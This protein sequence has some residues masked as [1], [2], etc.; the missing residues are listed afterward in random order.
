[1]SVS[2]SHVHYELVLSQICISISYIHFKLTLRSSVTRPICCVAW[3][4]SSEC[5]QKKEKCVKDTM[6]VTIRG[7]G[8]VVWSLCT[9]QQTETT[10]YAL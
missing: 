1:M 8:A 7:L 3:L 6:V 10:E 9:Q 2:E 4:C 5:Q